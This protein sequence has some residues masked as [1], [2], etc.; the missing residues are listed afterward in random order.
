MSET[1]LRVQ[2]EFGEMKLSSEG[3][4]D[5]V[6]QE[7]NDFVGRVCP[8]YQVASRILLIP[9]YA[10]LIEE[11]SGGIRV[12]GEG[13]VIVEQNSFSSDQLIGLAL[14]GFHIAFKIGKC[15]SDCASADEIARVIGKAVKTVRNTL[16]QMFKQ[17]LVDR[18]ER[19]TYRISARG[20]EELREAMRALKGGR[21][22]SDR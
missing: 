15:S 11:L 6:M 7:V 18:A 9:D 2:V 16:V 4:P 14:L 3:D 1:R 17:G 22:G 20:M 10:G 19:G 12:T 8:T 13:G 21:G 5:A